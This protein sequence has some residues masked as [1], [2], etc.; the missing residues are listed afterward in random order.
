MLAYHKHAI[1]NMSE[2]R[3]T[4]DSK[5]AG[6]PQT[7]QAASKRSGLAFERLSPQC[8][9]SECS[10]LQKEH[11]L[12]TAWSH[13]LLTGMFSIKHEQPG[14]P[15]PQKKGDGWMLYELGLT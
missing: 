15:K 3:A 11:C 14:Q 13:R 7:G 6:L 2:K 9:K 8:N 1:A 12:P 4:A 10:R 5:H